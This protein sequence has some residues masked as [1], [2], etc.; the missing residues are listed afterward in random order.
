MPA[1]EAE[2]RAATSAADATM[3]WSSC[4][5]AATLGCRFSTLE[6]HVRMRVKFKPR[7]SESSMTSEKPNCKKTTS[8]GI[9]L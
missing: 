5:L 8:I 7:Q 1:L 2:T 3:S 4:P 9:G 6:E